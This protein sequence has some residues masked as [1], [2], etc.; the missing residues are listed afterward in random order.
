MRRGPFL[1][2]AG[3]LTL[4][5]VLAGGVY[6]YDAAHPRTIAPGVTVNGVD[7]GGLSKA[8]ARAK[9]SRALV[10]PLQRSVAIIL[11]SGERMSLS[12]GQ[13]HLRL[14]VDAAA[15]TAYRLS[16]R[17]SILSRSWRSLTGQHLDRHLTV[18]LSYSRAAVRALVGRVA[19]QVD[20]SPED[21]SV[22]PEGDQLVTS[23][24]SDGVAVQRG[25]LRRAVVRR[26]VAADGSNRVRVPVR[27]LTPEVTEADLGAQYPSY[28]VV[29][30]DAYELKLFRNLQLVKTYTIAV[31]QQ[32]LETPAGLYDIQD[33][34][35]DPTWHVPEEAWAGDLAGKTIPPGPDNP[36]KA[37]WM[38]FNGGAGIHGTADEASLGSA[39]SHGCIRM[40]VPDVEELYDQVTVGTPVYVL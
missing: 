16:Q 1:A 37:R 11:P 40:S 29:N 3:V 21:A 25:A 8:Q 5:L 7:I 4:L 32:G 23:P 26:L 20:R 14:N 27:K 24:G 30:R 22:Q 17:G 10:V 2:L 35:V 13:A 31:G 12:P 18:S 28:I 9:L 39:A 6:A 15:E 36:L 33:K 38:G 34:Q 19:D